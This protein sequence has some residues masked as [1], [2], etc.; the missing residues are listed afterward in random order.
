[1]EK[2][3]KGKSEPVTL[4]SNASLPNVLIDK[5]H[6]LRR[7]DNLCMLRFFSSLP[8]GIFEQ[9]RILVPDQLIRNFLDTTCKSYNYYPKPEEEIRSKS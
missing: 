2:K 7:D 6:T 1:M 8:E 4:H 9:S 3:E 5:I